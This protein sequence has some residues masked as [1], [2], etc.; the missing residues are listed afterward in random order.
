[1]FTVPVNI[2]GLP[3]LSVNCGYDGDGMPIGMQLIG[4]PYCEKTLLSLAEIFE[5]GGRE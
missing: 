2:A 1:M 4:K 5:K 3:A